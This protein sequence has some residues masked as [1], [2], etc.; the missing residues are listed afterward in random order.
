MNPSPPTLSPLPTGSDEPAR[1]SVRFAASIGF[2]IVLSGVILFGLSQTQKTGTPPEAPTFEDLRAVV[3]PPPPPPP[4]QTDL[5]AETPPPP[6]TIEAGAPESRMP[7]EVQLAMAAPLEI[8]RPQVYL[9]VD[10]V[11]G[12]FKPSSG[13]ALG[14]VRRVFNES[15]V[16]QAVVALHRAAPKIHAHALRGTKAR[17]VLL[18]FVVG[19]DGRAHDMRVL[20]SVT[21][22]V[23][24]LV[25]EALADWTFRPAKR[26]KIAV[27]QW[28]QLPV[29][30]NEG[31]GNPLRLN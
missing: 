21:P 26:N 22:E 17:R 1:D 11:P 15:E 8:P 25:M 20:Q 19:T 14:N 4:A 23:D 31:S 24:R 12:A 3:L 13:N 9:P 18:L 27:R 6:L 30:L 5:P 2:S 7:D 29:D 10:L 16:D 28:V